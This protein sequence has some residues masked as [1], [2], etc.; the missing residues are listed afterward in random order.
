MW[1]AIGTSLG[2][3]VFVWAGAFPVAASAYIFSQ[4]L[5]TATKPLFMIWINRHAPS[6]VRATVISMYWQANASG[7]IIGAPI[8]GAIGSLHSLRSALTAASLA[9]LPVVPLYRRQP[10]E[11]PG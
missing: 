6:A 4:V 11:P 10:D 1:L 5:R 9:L 2:N 7:H 8:L 3:L